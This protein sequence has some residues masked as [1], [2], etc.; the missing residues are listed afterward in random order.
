MSHTRENSALAQQ[1]ASFEKQTNAQLVDFEAR[2]AELEKRLTTETTARELLL[3]GLTDRVDEIALN[4]RHGLAERLRE[5][6]DA[7]D[8]SS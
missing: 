5:L 3:A 2:L 4:L 7:V 1:F 6:A 8:I